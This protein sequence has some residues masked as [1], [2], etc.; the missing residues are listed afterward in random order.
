MPYM[1][2]STLEGPKLELYL[3]LKILKTITDA[4]TKSFSIKFALDRVFVNS[5]PDEDRLGEAA[6]KIM[7]YATLRGE[8]LRQRIDIS[9]PWIIC[10]EMGRHQLTPGSSRVLRRRYGESPG[11]KHQAN[12]ETVKSIR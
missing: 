2:D 3:L 10:R 5:V 1:S 11:G 9:N 8:K 4:D 7:Q 12:K 6:I